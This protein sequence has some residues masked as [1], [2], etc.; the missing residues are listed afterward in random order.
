MT[1]VPSRREFDIDFFRGWVCLSLA[2]LHFFHVLLEYFVRLFGERVD[3]FVVNIRLGV[4]S[5]FILAGF[6]MAHMMRPLP[7]ES[8]S[9]AGYVKRRFYRLIIPFWIA[10][11]IFVAYRY[12]IFNFFGRGEGVIPLRDVLAQLFLVLEFFYESSAAQ[13]RVSPIGYWSMI[14]LEQFYL[15]WL[16]LYA[17]C[18]AVFR[19]GSPAG[20][21]TAAEHAMVV[22][23][24]AAFIASLSCW[25]LGLEHEVR[26]QL[27]V[28]GVFLTLGMLVYWSVRQRYMSPFFRLAMIGILV[29]AVWLDASKMYKAIISVSIFIPLARGTRVPD[30]MLVRF[31]AYCGKRSY[32]IYLMHP[33]FGM[34]F[35][36]LAVKFTGKGDWLAVPILFGAIGVSIVAAAVF[37]KYVETPCQAKSRRVPYRRKVVAD[38]LSVPK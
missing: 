21:Y 25:W 15:I 22:L 16:A 33:I 7:G 18:L 14:S 26:W 12:A 23:T 1:A 20:R 38:S 9:I 10:V 3:W 17:C 35:I 37:F 29:S 30:C 13:E 32:S 34:A 24:F 6:M 31:L 11:L 2:A 4:E 19:R 8:V 28:Y 27:A 36:S 5:F